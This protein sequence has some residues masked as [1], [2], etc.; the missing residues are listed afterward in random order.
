MRYHK[1]IFFPDIDKLK[2]VNNKLNGLKWRY[3]KH[4][5]DSLKYR[6]INEGKT[7]QFIKKLVL[8]EQDIFEYY[9]FS[10]VINKLCYRVKFKHGQDLVLVIGYN[11]NLITV[12]INRAG[13][14]HYTLNEDLYI[15]G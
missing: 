11:K 1:K 9:I 5:L 7:L 12:Y 6:A 15:T 14:K 2:I 10:G 8:N 4:C 13:D 3:S